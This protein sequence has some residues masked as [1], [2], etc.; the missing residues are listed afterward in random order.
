MSMRTRPPRAVGTVL[1][2]E[3]VDVGADAGVGIAEVVAGVGS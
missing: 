2:Q 1:G 3:R